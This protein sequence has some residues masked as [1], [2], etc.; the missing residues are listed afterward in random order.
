MRTQLEEYQEN[1]ENLKE[2]L[3]KH[4]TEESN[5]IKENYESLLHEKTVEVEKLSTKLSQASKTIEAL[6]DGIRRQKAAFQRPQQQLHND[7][8]K[9]RESAATQSNA[10]H[11]QTDEISKVN[12]L[13]RKELAEKT[14]IIKDLK[15]KVSFSLILIDQFHNAKNWC[16]MAKF[17][18][19]N[20]YYLLKFGWIKLKFCK[21]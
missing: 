14:E 5:K 9:G 16:I 1:I 11:I 12:D 2:H 4:A 21:A 8:V 13:L 10:S 18:A 6:K 20:R 15:A 7:T 17:Q 3:E 19:F